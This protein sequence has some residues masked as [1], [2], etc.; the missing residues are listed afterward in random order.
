V[1]AADPHNLVAAYGLERIHGA[2]GSK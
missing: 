2:T 1:L